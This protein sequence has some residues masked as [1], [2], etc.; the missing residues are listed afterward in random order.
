MKTIIYLLRHAESAP[1]RDLPE[2][3]WPLSAEGRRQAMDLKEPLGSLEIDHIYSS[4]YRRAVASVQPFAREQHRRIEVVPDLRERKLLDTFSDQWLAVVEQ[5]WR[6]FDFALPN[7]ESGN[8]CKARMGRCV[9]SLAAAHPGRNIL[10]STHG[11]AIGLF[12][13]ILDLSFGF[14]EWSAIKT[15]DLFK[16]TYQDGLRF[17]DKSFTYNHD[18]GERHEHDG[19][20]L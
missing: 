1:S 10:A 14:E 19:G 5:A 11:N 6:N 12:L 2:A 13:N 16:I 17:W 7:C 18:Q 3:D 4:P 9:D 20:N 15:P 8:A